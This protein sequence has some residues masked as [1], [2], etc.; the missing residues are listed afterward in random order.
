MTEDRDEVVAEYEANGIDGASQLINNDP[1]YAQ[2]GEMSIP[3][4]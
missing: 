4:E 3:N 2:K 1:E